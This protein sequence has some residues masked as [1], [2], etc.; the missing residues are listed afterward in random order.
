M[1]ENTDAGV[2]AALAAKASGAH[3]VKTS[4]N[5][6]Y[7]VHPKDTVATEVTDAYGLKLTKPRYIRQTVTI[8]TADSLVDYVKRF[9][10][11][12][13]VLFAEIAANRIVALIDYHPAV[14]PPGGPETR[15]DTA[16]HVAHRAKMELPF[17]EEWALW[18]KISGKL[19]PQLEFARFV[20]ENAADIRA[21][22]G[23]ELLDAV[24]DLQANRKVNFIKAVRTSS[25]NE[26]FEFQDETR[27][28]TKGG[29]ELPTKFK[30]GLPVYFG[31]PETEVFAFLRW[32][33]DPSEGGLALGIQLHRVE[34]VRQ[35]VFKQIV[36]MVADRTG[37]P[38]VFGKSEN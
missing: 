5:R 35:A 1:T 15:S 4:D 38:A 28:T 17:S 22:D 30:L 32:K 27:T 21:P 19:M 6:E 7:L 25:D 29:I 33:L 24:R 3:V 37:C 14:L 13:T 36:Q 12:D 31:E 34:H 11:P 9:K 8:E 2:I 16:A 10:G 26:N 23:G 18:T 20:E